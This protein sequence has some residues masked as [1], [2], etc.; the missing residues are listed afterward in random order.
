MK[1]KIVIWNLFKKY[2]YKLLSLDRVRKSVLKLSTFVT[3]EM[4][5]I[6]KS[7]MW[8]YKYKPCLVLAF[9]QK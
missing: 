3:A 1:A 8:V 2:F 5:G 9:L 4:N 7:L 6:L